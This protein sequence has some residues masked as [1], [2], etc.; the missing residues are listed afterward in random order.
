[1]SNKK[2]ADKQHTDESHSIEEAIIVEGIS[3]EDENEKEP[4]LED[5]VADLNDRNMRLQAEMENVRQRTA[6]EMADTRRFASLN[7]MKDLLDVSDNIQRAI[8]SSEQSEETNSL[9]EGFKMVAGQLQTVLKKHHCLPIEAEGKPFDPNFH[10][11]IQQFP[12]D[13][14]P[15]GHVAQV[16]QMGYTLHDRVIRPTQVLVSTG[17][18][19]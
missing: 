17:P 19:E 5:Q 6:R 13:E 4:T 11:A 18:P 8:E 12:S 2:Q 1:M 7:F 16:T 9:L 3:L 15:A 14:I 10:E